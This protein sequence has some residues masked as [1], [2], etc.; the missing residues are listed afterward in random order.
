MRVGAVVAAVVTLLM[1]TNDSKAE[2]IDWTKLDLASLDVEPID[3][4]LLAG[5]PVLVVN[6]A[7]LCGFTPQ[8][9]GLQ[10]LWDTYRDRGLVVLGVPSDDFGGQEYDASG[11]IKAFCEVNYG[12]N[13]P[14]LERQHVKG[15]QAHPLFAWISKQAGSA[16]VPRW[17]FY[18]YLIA[19]DGT[20]VDWYAST[21]KPTSDTVVT[22]IESQLAAQ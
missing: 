14:M 2:A 9:E 17:N 12:I 21:T 19:A 4:A 6:T 1:G 8:Y 3:P 18:K 13:F 10:K 20:F 7:S 22:A 16:G 15:S 11:E 5:H